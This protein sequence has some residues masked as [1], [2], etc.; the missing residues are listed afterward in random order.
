MPLSAGTCFGSYGTAV[1]LG[2]GGM[3]DVYRARDT[4]LD[5]TVAITGPPRQNT[6]DPRLRE[7]LIPAIVLGDE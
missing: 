2:A 6:I 5:R 4:P 3:R 1:V 7:P